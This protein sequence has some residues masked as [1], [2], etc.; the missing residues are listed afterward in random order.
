M[1]TTRRSTGSL[2][3]RSKPKPKPSNQTK[4]AFTNR[5]TKS[6]STD[7]SSS[8]KPAKPTTTTPQELAPA[9]IDIIQDDEEE[10]DDDDEPDSANTSLASVVES[11]S[12]AV[13]VAVGIVD[14]VRPPPP[15]LLLDELDERARG[16]GEAQVQRYWK[17]REALRRSKRVHVQDLDLH[18]QLLRDFDTD[19]RYGVS[20]FSS[21]SFCFVVFLLLPPCSIILFTILLI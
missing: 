11:P 19:G 8:A 17:E 12:V 6:N 10:D 4:L 15:T 14:D 16:V 3:S 13:A 1:P 2:A 5:I 9:V 21:F 7:S 18:E 20:I